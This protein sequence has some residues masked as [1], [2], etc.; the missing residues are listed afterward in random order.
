MVEF[1]LW[2]TFMAKNQKLFAKEN[3]FSFVHIIRKT[4]VVLATAVSVQYWFV[5]NYIDWY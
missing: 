4:N 2:P 1:E 3:I 5:K